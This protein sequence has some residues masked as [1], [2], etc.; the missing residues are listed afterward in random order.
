MNVEYERNENGAYHTRYNKETGEPILNKSEHAVR[1]YNTLDMNGHMLTEKHKNGK[2]KYALRIFLVDD[3][4]TP[5]EVNAIAKEHMDNKVTDDQILVSTITELDDEGRPTRLVRADEKGALSKDG[6]ITFSFLNTPNG[7]FGTT[8]NPKRG[9]N[10]RTLYQMFTKN[11]LNTT[12]AKSLPALNPSANLDAPVPKGYAE[13]FDKKSMTYG[14]LHTEAV[15]WARD[16]YTSTFFGPLVELCKAGGAVADIAGTSNGIMLRQKSFNEDG[17]TGAKPKNDVL[18]IVER[19]GVKLAPRTVGSKSL[20]GGSIIVTGTE[21]VIRNG[22]AVEYRQG[23][24]MLQFDKGGDIMPLNARFMNDDDINTTLFLLNELNSG[25]KAYSLDKEVFLPKGSKMIDAAGNVY[26]DTH[27]IRIMPKNG[28][29]TFS[30]IRSLMFWGITYKQKGVKGMS[31]SDIY[32]SKGDIIFGELG[33]D[34]TGAVTSLSLSKVNDAFVWAKNNNKSIMEYEDAQFQKFVHYLG[35]KYA[36]V[37]RA[38]LGLKG[39]Y[40]H[41]VAKKQSDGT[42]KLDWERYTSYNHY[43]L[44]GKNKVLSTDAVANDNFPIL[45]SKNVAIAKDNNT[46]KPVIRPIDP[47]S[48]LTGTTTAYDEAAAKPSAV[49]TQ[50]IDP[51][52]LELAKLSKVSKQEAESLEKEGENKPFF[53]PS[54][55]NIKP[56]VSELFESNLS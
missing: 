5:D 15:D 34:N 44:T 51:A 1:W 32:I 3:V 27:G 12:S 35:T 19:K 18:P 54:T 30:A 24:P 17:T 28:S 10:R 47:K 38:N 16:H 52:L 8:D 36:S 39:M 23:V 2:P 55:N 20:K 26:D 6:E 40:F 25:E 33:K 31:P 9:I 49:T 13:I 14:E 37:S 7:I 41:P 46:F 48:G 45:G 50:N 56:G 29:N 4:N 53:S 11:L 21:G 42:Y 22:E 43:L